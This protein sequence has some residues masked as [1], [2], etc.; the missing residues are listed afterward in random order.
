MGQRHRE[1]RKQ[2]KARL[3]EVVK[4]DD[5]RKYENEF[6]ELKKRMTKAEARRRLLFRRT[7]S[8]ESAV[9]L[10]RAYGAQAAEEVILEMGQRALREIQEHEDQLVFAMLDQYANEATVDCVHDL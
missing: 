10:L 8:V 1:K 3:A 6:G 7:V 2:V 5:H 9:D 4:L